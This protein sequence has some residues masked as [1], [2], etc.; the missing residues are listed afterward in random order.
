MISWTFSRAL[1]SHSVGEKLP[2]IFL[3]N[4]YKRTTY[5]PFVMQF[6]ILLII[7]IIKNKIKGRCLVNVTICFFVIYWK[8]INDIFL[9]FILSIIPLFTTCSCNLCY[10][11]GF[12]IFV[13]FFKKKICNTLSQK[14]W[15]RLEIYLNFEALLNFKY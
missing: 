2:K 5:N 10:S 14:R 9:T 12:W 13:F 7:I 1:F 15:F 11:Q 3:S 6:F 4:D 8:M